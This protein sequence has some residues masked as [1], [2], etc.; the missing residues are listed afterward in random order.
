[1]SD[2][3]CDIAVGAVK[4]KELLNRTTRQKINRK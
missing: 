2:K 1:V 3:N 4:H